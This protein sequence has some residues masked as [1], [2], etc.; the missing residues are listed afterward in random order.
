MGME[1]QGR[2]D[3]ANLARV[4]GDKEKSDEIRTMGKLMEIRNTFSDN[5]ISR[6]VKLLQLG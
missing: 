1:H 2:S 3:E 4:G 6:R 5:W